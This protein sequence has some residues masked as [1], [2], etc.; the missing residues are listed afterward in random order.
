MTEQ[1]LAYLLVGIARA[2]RAIVRGLTQGD[3]RASIG[4]IDALRNE[5]GISSQM[6]DATLFDLP[7]RILLPMIAGSLNPEEQATQDAWISAQL[8]RLLA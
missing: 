8:Q 1:Q 7:A 3:E 2:Q 5:A 4:V 6:D